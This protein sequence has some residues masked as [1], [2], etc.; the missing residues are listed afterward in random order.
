MLLNHLRSKKNQI[1][2]FFQ[3]Y[4]ITGLENSY[5]ETFQDNLCIPT[6]TLLQ[7]IDVYHVDFFSLDVENVELDVLQNFP[8][9]Q[10]IVDVWAIEHTNPDLILFADGS[11]IG[12]YE[13]KNLISF[14]ET[15]GYYL[16]DVFCVQIADYIFVRRN[17]DIFKKL[18]VPQKFWKRRGLCRNKKINLKLIPASLRDSRHW[19]DIKFKM[20]RD[21]LQ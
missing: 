5:Y 4:K 3:N 17:S 13:D 9:D 18:E 1:Y 8:F 16:F 15:K 19:P 10:I 11:K 21:T 20:E 7:A 12:E 14:M 6:K 2:S